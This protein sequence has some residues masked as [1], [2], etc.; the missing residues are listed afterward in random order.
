VVVVGDPAV[1]KSALVQMLSSG[2]QNFPKQYNMTCGVD[3]KVKI[4]A[5]PGTSDMVELHLFDMGGQDVFAELGSKFWEGASAVL[6]V[7]DVTRQHTLDACG[8]RYQALL[9]ALQKNAMLGSLV[10]NKADLHDRL[11]VPRS[12]GMHLAEQMGLQYFETSAV[13]ADGIAAPFEHIAAEL[14]KQASETGDFEAY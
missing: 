3:F 2:G 4:L 8:G 11:V 7:Y 6:L 9:E 13:E 1:G 10:A 14:L 5:V 12:A